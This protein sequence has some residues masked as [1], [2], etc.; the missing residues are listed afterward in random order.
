[1]LFSSSCM[2]FIATFQLWT[3]S[4]MPPLLLYN[5]TPSLYQPGL[6]TQHRRAYTQP[7]IW[8]QPPRTHPHPNC[9]HWVGTSSTDAH[10]LP[11]VSSAPELREQGQSQGYV[12]QDHCRQ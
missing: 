12:Q 7:R 6:Q 3:L 5:D 10:S 9:T 1:M 11:Y 8:R 2:H 4:H